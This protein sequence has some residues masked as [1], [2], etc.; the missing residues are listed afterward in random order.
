MSRP[1]LTILALAL[2]GALALAGCGG[3]GDDDSTASAPASTESTPSLT[4][5][6]LISQGDAICAEVN[7]AVGS[8]G[9]SG[10]GVPDQITQV[11]TLYTGLV[12]RLEDLGEPTEKAGYPEFIE[13][14][15]EL[16]KVEGEV[17]VATEQADT[18]ALGEA[19]TR[20]TPA[21]EEFESVAGAYGFESCSEGPSAPQVTG[22][23]AATG[24]EIEGGVAPEATEE[25]EAEPEAEPAPETGGGEEPAPEGGGTG[26]GGGGAEGGEGGGGSSGGIGAG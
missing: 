23:G 3:G 24:E 8:V 21:L 6:E 2:T 9:G 18:T 17:K 25:P 1:R 12:E 26:A 16:A 10:A 13:A 14:A 11:S 19:A 4:K 7:A 20:A 5:A 15:E 22:E